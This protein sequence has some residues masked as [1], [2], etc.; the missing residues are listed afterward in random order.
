MLH[1]AAAVGARRFDLVLV[2]GLDV[3]PAPLAAP[4]ALGQVRLEQAHGRGHVAPVGGGLAGGGDKPV[5]RHGG[6]ELR[7]QGGR[8]VRAAA[9]S[10]RRRR[11]RR[12]RARRPSVAPGDDGHRA[13]G[14]HRGAVW[15]GAAS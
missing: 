5:Q 6:G 13:R 8:P 7:V 4:R 11:R 15:G 10:A 9:A 2:A 14:R 12:R 3:R 1:P